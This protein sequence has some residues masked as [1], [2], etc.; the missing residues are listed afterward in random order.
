MASYQTVPADLK[1]VI[2]GKKGP[3]FFF[4]CGG[5]PARKP[6]LWLQEALP[7]SI[8]RWLYKTLL[9]MLYLRTQRANSYRRTRTLEAVRFLDQHWMEMWSALQATL[10]SLLGVKICDRLRQEA[11]VLGQGSF[12]M[13]HWF[14]R[15]TRREQW[16]LGLRVDALLRLCVAFCENLCWDD[17]ALSES[18]RQI[19]EHEYHL[20]LEDFKCPLIDCSVS[21]W[22]CVMSTIPVRGPQVWEYQ[23]WK[24]QHRPWKIRDKQAQH[25]WI[26]KRTEAE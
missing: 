5:N 17:W 16:P 21:F 10:P 8:V 20:I 24:K 3:Q 25:L 6:R 23:A 15:F 1:E 7:E 19:L 14:C 18:Q 2:Y 9:N 26:R 22:Q 12:P 11:V 4:K 13:H